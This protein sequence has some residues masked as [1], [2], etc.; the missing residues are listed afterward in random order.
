MVIEVLLEV[1]NQDVRDILIADL[2]DMQFYG[3]EEDDLLLK[4]YIEEEY[5]REEEL[6]NLLNQYNLKYSKSIIEERNWNEIW[7]KD[8][9]SVCVGNFCSIRADFHAS[10]PNVE[11]EIIITPKMS[12]GTG[13]HATTYLMIQQMQHIDFASKTIADFGTGTGVLSIL[14]EKLGSR[15]IWAVDNDDWSI[16]NAKENFE[17]NS[18]MKINLEK[19]DTFLSSKKFDI[20][21]ANINKNVILENFHSLALALEVKGFLILSGLLQSDKSVVIKEAQ[22]LN[23]VHLKTVEKDQW[24]SMVLSTNSTNAC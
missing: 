13:H 14:A 4:A 7:E 15:Y 16:E 10:V 12:F 19:R 8:F 22:A 21:L 9:S 2:S 17:R 23:L 24:I 3:F 6:N 5:L 11:H 20:I 18:C 1:R